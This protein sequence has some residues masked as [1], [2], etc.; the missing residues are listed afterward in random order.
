M[1]FGGKR[2]W[3]SITC[4][5]DLTSHQKIKKTH[6]VLLWNRCTVK[7]LHCSE[8]L[9]PGHFSLKLEHG[10]TWQI[11]ANRLTR[12]SGNVGKLC[13]RLVAATRLTFI[14]ASFVYTSYRFHTTLPAQLLLRDVK[15][16]I[17]I[18]LHNCKTKFLW[19]Q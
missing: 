1:V 5:L 9:P 6:L 2:K 11:S 14:N 18:S 4:R 7:I 13:L 12:A 17:K 16:K 19:D 3:L 10:G 8:I 15:K